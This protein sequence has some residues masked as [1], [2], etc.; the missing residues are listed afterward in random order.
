MKVDHSL[1][2]IAKRNFPHVAVDF[3][4]I[5]LWPR[6]CRNK[7]NCYLRDTFWQITQTK[8]KRVN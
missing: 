6:K 3:R 4:L 1:T 2:L 5:S 7:F 8:T